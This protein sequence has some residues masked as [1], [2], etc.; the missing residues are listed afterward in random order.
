MNT[1]IDEEGRVRKSKVRSVRADSGGG[2]NM[3]GTLSHAEHLYI[4][5]S[6]LC[7]NQ[8]YIKV[9]QSSYLSIFNQTHP[10][11]W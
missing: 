10:E 11:R 7:E 9:F 3:N 1:Q 8:H 5:F 2:E 4:L 6:E